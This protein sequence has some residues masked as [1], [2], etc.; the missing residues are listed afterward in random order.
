MN[1]SQ[2]WKEQIGPNIKIVA[3]E[4]DVSVSLLYKMI[5]GSHQGDWLSKIE[6]VIG[7]TD[8]HAIAKYIALKSGGYFIPAFDAKG[9]SDSAIIPQ[10]AVECSELLCAFGESMADGVIT[11]D[12]ITRMKKELA[13][14]VGVVT[15]L[16]DQS[17][18]DLVD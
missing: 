15:G 16:L 2:T 4:V 14:L 9:M 3:D 17:E 7:A 5:D 13:D 8:S 1:K 18:K 10:L 6:Q 12:E 11:A